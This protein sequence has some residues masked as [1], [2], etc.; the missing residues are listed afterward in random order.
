MIKQIWRT[1]I[2]AKTYLVIFFIISSILS[3]LISFS[4]IPNFN[5]NTP[6]GMIVFRLC[7][8]YISSF[9][10]YFIVVHIPKQK[11]RDYIYQY[12]K[13]DVCNVVDYG[14][15]LSKHLKEESKIS[16]EKYPDKNNILNICK[17]VKSD[18]TIK[19]EKLLALM[20]Q[21]KL[22]T[23]AD[24]DDIYSKIPFID[25]E[26]IYLIDNIKDCLYFDRIDSYNKEIHGDDLAYFH[27]PM[28]MYFESIKE[29]DD[30]VDDKFK[31]YKRRK[32]LPKELKKLIKKGN[33]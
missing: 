12:I 18:S 23:F 21:Y 17:S 20:L 30:Y 16:F 24:I 7:M 22:R 1:I 5:Y 9:I 13:N 31:Y 4:E 6:L 27:I 19:N 8:S 2:T 28:I 26:L 11:D 33:Y 10:F 32:P 29:L 3:L 14:K 25:G 15:N